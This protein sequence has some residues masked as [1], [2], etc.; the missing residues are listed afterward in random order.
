MC[1][2]AEKQ[3][4]YMEIYNFL[5]KERKILEENNYA[6]NES[7]KYRQYILFQ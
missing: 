5:N 7:S 4:F 3:A 2:P 1:K 6:W